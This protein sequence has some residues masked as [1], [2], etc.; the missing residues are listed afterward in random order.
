MADNIG[1]LRQALVTDGLLTKDDAQYVYNGNVKWKITK[2]EKKTGCVFL[3]KKD[4]QIASAGNITLNVFYHT[5]QAIAHEL[6][7]ALVDVP[8]S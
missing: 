6:S 5:P 7:G 4:G 1:V 8:T 2:V 3:I